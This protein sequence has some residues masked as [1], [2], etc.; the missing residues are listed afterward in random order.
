MHFLQGDISEEEMRE[1]NLWLGKS[2]ENKR[3][4]F[5]MKDIYDRRKGG[6][7]PDS[8]E[9]EQSWLRL[10]R[11]LQSRSRNRWWV[12]P[13]RYAVAAAIAVFVT[14][15]AQK[16]FDAQAPTYAELS[17]EAGPRM[18]HITLPDGTK[19]VLNG[20]TKFRFPDRFNGDLRE[21]FLDGEA[22]FSVA[23]NPAAPFVVLTSR[24]KICVTG[25]TFNVMDYAADDYAI[26]TL[27]G[28]SVTVQELSASGKAGATHQL[29]PGEQAYWDKVQQK[30]TLSAVQIDTSR[31]WVNK[32]YHFRDE[33][34]LNITQRLEKIYGIRI[35]IADEALKAERYTGTFPTNAGIENVLD[36]FNFEKNFS[37]EVNDDGVVVSKK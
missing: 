11:K 36:I 4:L 37:F 30:M 25:T 6:L 7:L 21:V 33:T 12:A 14:L 1:L 31:T 23:H 9:V 2:E 20:S 17:V 10:Q 5:Q 22:F 34:L 13:L 27:V 18:S 32:I 19:V 3:L 26:T 16:L 24:Q 28:G 29:H 35:R 8:K 15:A